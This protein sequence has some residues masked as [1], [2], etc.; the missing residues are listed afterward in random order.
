MSRSI[1]GLHHPGFALPKVTRARLVSI[2]LNNSLKVVNRPRPALE[3]PRASERFA[4]SDLDAHLAG[5]NMDAARSDGPCRCYSH[6]VVSG[7]DILGG[8]TFVRAPGTITAHG[9]AESPLSLG[10]PRRAV[11]EI[12]SMCPAPTDRETTLDRTEVMALKRAFILVVK[13]ICAAALVGVVISLLRMVISR[14]CFYRGPLA[15]GLLLLLACTC[16]SLHILDT[17]RPNT[18]AQYGTIGLIA[19]L[20]TGFLLNRQAI[21]ASWEQHASYVDRRLAWMEILIT[22]LIGS[23]V[24]IAIGTVRRAVGRRL[25]RP[26]KWC[27][28]EPSAKEFDE[29]RPRVPERRRVIQLAVFGIGLV[30]VYHLFVVDP[31][32]IDSRGVV[33]TLVLGGA[34][35]ARSSEAIRSSSKAGRIQDLRFSADGRALRTVDTNG[36]ICFWDVTNLALLRK[37]SV[38]AGYIVGSIRPSDG[39]YALCSDSHAALHVQVVDLDTG[40]SNCQAGLPLPWEVRGWGRLAY[41]RNIHWLSGPEIMYTGRIPGHR[42]V[43]EDWWRLN[44][45]TGEVIDYGH[46]RSILLRGVRHN[47]ERMMGVLGSDVEVTEDGKHLFL[48]GGGGKGSP[49]SRAGQIY[50]ET[51]QTRDLGRI[52][53][54]VNGPFGLVP[55]GKYFHLSLHIY[56]RRSLNLVAAKDFP[57][58]DTTIRTVSFS[59]DGSRYAASLRQ[60]KRGEEPRTAVLVHETLTSRILGA[61]LPPTGAALLRFSQDGTQLAVAYDDGT[62]ELRKLPSGQ[63]A[64]PVLP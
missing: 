37:V 25:G 12:T 10:V 54:P 38:P 45:Q 32:V 26:A 44:Y 40:E 30:V 61:F 35:D 58:D 43:S 1:S 16:L 27:D 19:G 48:I 6:R 31:P 60:H 34:A 20:A 15:T 23:L 52:D 7:P 51:F 42:A 63:P 18:V 59:P 11:P 53:R 47:L 13:P 62:L 56:D 2:L 22:A 64:R 49:P 4:R 3:G 36:T 39:R 21:S 50:L 33:E 14:E 17:W 46:P 8:V 9:D 41:A 55:G 29:L 24:G 57:G 5:L 28:V